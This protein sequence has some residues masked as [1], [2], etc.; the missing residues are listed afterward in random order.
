MSGHDDHI[1]DA[2]DLDVVDLTAAINNQHVSSNSHDHH[3]ERH[4]DTDEVSAAEPAP[5]VG[6]LEEADVVDQDLQHPGIDATMDMDTEAD[7]ELDLDEDPF[8]HHTNAFSDGEDD[9]WCQ[10]AD[11][12]FRDKW[13]TLH[14]KSQLRKA[15]LGMAMTL[16]QKQKERMKEKANQIRKQAREIQTLTD[17][18]D[19]LTGRRTLHTEI[20]WP[21]LL[22]NFVLGDHKHSYVSIYRLSC[23]ESNIAPHPRQV[24]PGLELV[25][26]D[27]EEQPVVQPMHVLQQFN[28]EGLA[29]TVQFKIL[30]HALCFHKQTIHVLS[31]LDPHH[32]PDVEGDAWQEDDF[33][34]SLLHRFHI[35]SRP[36]SLTNATLPNT[37]LAP[38]LV[39]K[40]FNFW[41]ASIFYGE[42]SFAFSSLGE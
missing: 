19:H 29:H 6:A 11:D 4:M 21:Q 27:A 36:V 37:L 2:A 41:G 9:A 24:L 13:D 30:Q 3:E 5:V 18:L 8:T 25:E 16:M 22:K 12:M 10:Q 26:P 32:P 28:F 40:K 15:R 7:A 31:R 1:D 42:N 34:F 35:G 20:T 14:T 33:S 38:L 17:R 39:C 23:R